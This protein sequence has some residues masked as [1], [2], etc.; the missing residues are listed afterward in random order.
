MAKIDESTG[1]VAAAS[2]CELPTTTPTD[3]AERPG[4]EDRRADLAHRGRKARR[5]TAP[6]VAAASTMSLGDARMI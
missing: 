4:D 2:R 3:D 1:A 5:K 6:S